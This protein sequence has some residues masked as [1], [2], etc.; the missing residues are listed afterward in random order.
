MWAFSVSVGFIL[1]ARLNGVLMALEGCGCR[2]VHVSVTGDKTGGNGRKI[3]GWIFRWLFKLDIHFQKTGYS[4][5]LPTHTVRGGRKNP[6]NGVECRKLTLLVR[7]CISI[8]LIIYR[9][10]W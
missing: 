1:R 6:K 5:L 4:K 9:I 2:K 8:Y 10:K 7:L 3:G